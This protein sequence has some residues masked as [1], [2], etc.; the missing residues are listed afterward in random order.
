MKTVLDV[1]DKISSAWLRKVKQINCLDTVGL[2]RKIKKMPHF[3]HFSR[4]GESDPYGK[5][6]KTFCK[7]LA[8]SLI[9]D[10]MFRKNKTRVLLCKRLSGQCRDVYMMVVYLVVGCSGLCCAVL[11]CTGMYWA[12]LGCTGLYWSLLG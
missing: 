5:F 1:T 6:D 7:S 2:Q 11:G 8:V 4:P 9:T 12:E 10:S 3:D